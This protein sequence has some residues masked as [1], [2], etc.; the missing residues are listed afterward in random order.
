MDYW[1]R[2]VSPEQ[3][4]ALKRARAVIAKADATM[5]QPRPSAATWEG[6][7]SEPAVV[8]KTVVH[9]VQKAAPRYV[10][11]DELNKG[12]RSLAKVTGA[13]LKEDVLPQRDAK[14][15]DLEHRLA[16]IEAVIAR[17][18]GLSQ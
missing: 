11:H 10:T 6:K 16:A 2:M 15:A 8:R 18:K 7:P 14:I 3:L 12:L 9:T 4:A 1:G 13:A 17:A 5:A